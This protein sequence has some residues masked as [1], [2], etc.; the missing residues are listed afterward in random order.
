MIFAKE[1]RNSIVTLKSL[2]ASK[3]GFI[4]GMSKVS[5]TWCRVRKRWPSFSV[6]RGIN[7]QALSSNLRTTCFVHLL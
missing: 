6:S 5:I 2:G 7:M 3:D 1:G 4:Q